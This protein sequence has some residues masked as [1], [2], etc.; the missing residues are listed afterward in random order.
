MKKSTFILINRY[1]C[2]IA[3]RT[4]QIVRFEKNYVILSHL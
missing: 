1:H 2:K 3:K 4:G